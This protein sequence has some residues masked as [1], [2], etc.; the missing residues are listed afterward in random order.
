MVNIDKKSGLV[1]PAVYPCYKGDG[2]CA[3]R[4][5][6]KD[7]KFEC[8]GVLPICHFFRITEKKERE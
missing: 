4:F 2:K 3:I 6:G 8:T 7:S 5:E 1:T